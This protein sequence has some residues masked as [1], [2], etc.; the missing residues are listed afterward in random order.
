MP[1]SNKIMNTIAKYPRLL[2]LGIGLAI[3]FTIGIAIGSVENNNVFAFLDPSKT[4]CN[5]RGCY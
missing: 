3:T 5:I 2:T 4:F 1:I